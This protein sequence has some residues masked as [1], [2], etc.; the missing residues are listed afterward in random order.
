M[1]AGFL[2]VAGVLVVCLFAAAY[3]LSALIDGDDR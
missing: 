1:S 3:A 2:M